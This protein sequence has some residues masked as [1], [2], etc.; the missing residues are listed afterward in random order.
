MKNPKPITSMLG[1]FAKRHGI[2]EQLTA[3]RIV[4]AAQGELMRQVMG[5]PLAQ[6]MLVLSYA[7]EV[8]V[9]ACRNAAARFDAQ[10]VGDAICRALES[11]FP[12]MTFHAQC[13]LRP[14]AWKRIL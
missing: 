12:T 4:D 5:T 11:Q 7:H 14:E 6:D 8:I 9:F 10:Q 3:H 2:K 13:I 1:S